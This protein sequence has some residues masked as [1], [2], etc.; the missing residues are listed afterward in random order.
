MM[1]MMIDAR[2]IVKIFRVI[3]SCENYTQL[4]NCRLW[5]ERLQYRIPS[6]YKSDIELEYSC[7]KGAFLR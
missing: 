1:N 7:K 5:L 6:E 3:N 4:V 2:G